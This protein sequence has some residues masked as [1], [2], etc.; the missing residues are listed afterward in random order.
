MKTSLTRAQLLE[1]DRNWRAM[2]G[3]IAYMAFI[4]AFRNQAAGEDLFQE[5]FLRLF[6][7]TY[8]WDPEAAPFITHVRRVMQR[9]K[10]SMRKKAEIRRVV[11]LGRGQENDIAA[12]APGPLRLLEMKQDQHLADQMFDEVCAELPEG[13]LARDC[14]EL[15]RDEICDPESQA[16]AL[17]VDVADVYRARERIKR[18]IALVIA[19]H[20]LEMP[21]MRKTGGTR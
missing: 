9:I 5:T 18:K 12:D 4:K 20:G 13:S 1:L 8:P 7:G 21:V 6:D 17:E 3:L 16:E 15:A 10:S 2:R 14:M 19:R 11:P